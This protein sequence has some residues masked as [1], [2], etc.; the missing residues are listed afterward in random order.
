[1]NDDMANWFAQFG[2]SGDDFDFNKLIAQLQQ[3]MASMAG[4][5]DGKGI[6]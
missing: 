3:A 6:D 2:G 1:M 4:T 5:S